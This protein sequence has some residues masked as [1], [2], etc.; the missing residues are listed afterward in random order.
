MCTCYR[1]LVDCHTVPQELK[2]F[3]SVIDSAYSKMR[4]GILTLMPDMLWNVKNSEY[5]EALNLFSLYMHESGM[6]F[7]GE[8]PCLDIKLEKGS[9]QENINLISDALIIAGGYR[10]F[11]GIVH[12]DIQEYI[13]G[14]NSPSLAKIISFIKNETR[15]SII[16]MTAKLK[17]YQER[18]I[19]DELKFV[20]R[21]KTIHFNKERAVGQHIFLKIKLEEAGFTIT[22]KADQSFVVMLNQLSQRGNIQSLGDVSILADDILM[23]ILEQ[24]FE[25]PIINET[26]VDAYFKQC[27]LFRL[28]E[29]RS[30]QHIGFVK[31]D[32]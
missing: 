9:V 6:D 28:K 5:D 26:T 2:R 20:T 30:K 3:I 17:E 31:G 15:G 13:K 14:S 11:K 1:N 32:D 4:C 23:F 25:V 27:E 22:E 21:L 29:N 8:V 19:E 18:E 10:C 16:I 24:G 12:I 7:S